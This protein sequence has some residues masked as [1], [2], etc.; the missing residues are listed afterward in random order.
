MSDARPP[1]APAA[2]SLLVLSDSLAY[3][4]PEGGLPADD[5]RIWPNLAG[6]ALGMHTELFG[7]IGWTT[8]DAWWALTQD[9]RMWAAVRH[10]RAVVIAIGG[11]DTLPSPLPTALREQI[12]YIRPVAVRQQVRSLYGWLQPRLSPLGWPLALPPAVTVDY[13]SK[14]HGALVAVRPDL[15]VVVALP[16]TH[17]SPYYGYVHTARARHTVAMRGWATRAGVPVLDFYPPTAAHFAA[18]DPEVVASGQA[19]DHNPDGIHWGFDCHR[20]V[21]EVVIEGVRAALSGEAS[22]PQRT[23]VDP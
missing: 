21:S 23:T 1:V 15:P 16:P 6:A 5:P 11:M 7:R 19:S 14:I 4:G 3:Y 2:R 10:A 18:V 12:R 13:L 22:G 20:S 8:R 9:P 17:R